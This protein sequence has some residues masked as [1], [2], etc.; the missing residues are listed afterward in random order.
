M[1]FVKRNKIP[2][3]RGVFSRDVLPKKI[4][5][6]ESGVINLDDDVGSGTHW[7]AYKKIGNIVHYFD[8]FG[9]LQPPQE[10]ARYFHTNGTS[11]IF[12][13]HKRYQTFNQYNCGH[14]CLNF[15]QNK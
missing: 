14:L 1:N 4:R 12:Y 10:A 15:L 5:K 8:S 6:N 11:Q 13:N 2:H 9:D 7:V 3:F